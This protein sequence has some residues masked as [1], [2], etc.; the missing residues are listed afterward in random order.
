MIEIAKKIKIYDFKELKKDIQNKIIEN[1]IDTIIN[2]TNFEELN[3][4]SNLYKAYKK[5]EELQTPWF[6]GSYIW[7]YDKKN[8]LKMCKSYNYLK[9]GEIYEIDMKIKIYKDEKLSFMTNGEMSYIIQKCNEC[10]PISRDEL[11]RCSRAVAAEEKIFD[12][13]VEKDNIL[14]EIKQETENLKEFYKK[15]IMEA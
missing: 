4:N 12:L 9:N 5:C 2:S 3:K 14:K 15:Y 7:D 8:I 13:K 6:L 1:F 10:K 11:M